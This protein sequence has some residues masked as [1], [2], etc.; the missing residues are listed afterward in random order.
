MIGRM[1][2]SQTNRDFLADLGTNSRRLDEAQRQ[3]STGKRISSPAD[4]PLGIA[5]A[6][7]LRQDQASTAAWSSNI[8]DSQT[9][10][11]TTD[12][13]LD[14]ATQVLQ[15]ARELAVQGANGALSTSARATLA[16]EVQGLLGQMVE[17]GNTAVGGRSIFGGTKTQSPAFSPTGSFQGNTGAITRETGPS[18]VIQVNVTGQQLMGPGGSVSDVFTTL[19]QLA[20]DLSSSN[21]T[22]IQASL[23]TLDA[24]ITNVNAIRG[25]VG[26]RVN[27]LELSKSRFETQGIATSDQLS[28]IEDVDMAQAI[29]DL[30]TREDLYRASLGV[31]GRVLQPSLLD[32][33]R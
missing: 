32:F 14:N 6:L 23:S 27:Q 12:T 31:G 25:Q 5:Q 19:S 22:G 13:A 17:I 11:S 4:D 8:D 3:V 18:Q 21:Q 16:N 29:T 24:H 30:K 10:L 2:V 1:T 9:W 7:R 33:L 20:S 28:S 15:R 26:A